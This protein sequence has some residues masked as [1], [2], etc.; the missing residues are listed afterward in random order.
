MSKDVKNCLVCANTE[1]H[2][3]YSLCAFEYR[4]ELYYQ[5]GAVVIVEIFPRPIGWLRMSSLSSAVQLRGE[6]YLTSGGPPPSL[7]SPHSPGV[8]RRIA[9]DLQRAQ[10]R[11]VPWKSDVPFSAGVQTIEMG[12]AQKRNTIAKPLQLKA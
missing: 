9:P 3:C 10:P 6:V 2:A 11:H 12:E 5:S 1:L 8:R 4:D 7:P